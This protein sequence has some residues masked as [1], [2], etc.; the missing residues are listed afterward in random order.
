MKCGGR[1]AR[2]LLAVVVGLGVSARAVPGAAAA[3]TVVWD[4]GGDGVHWSDAANW[5]GDFAPQSGD[6]L[7][8]QAWSCTVASHAPTVNDFP[9]GFVVG[10]VLTPETPFGC[11]VTGNPVELH[12]DIVAASQNGTLTDFHIA[13]VV[14]A[15]DSGQRGFSSFFSDNL[16]LAGHTFTVSGYA[17]L[18]VRDF[19]GG[20]TVHVTGSAAL[21]GSGH[22]RVVMESQP[23]NVLQL[24]G[25]WGVVTI[26]S[27][28]LE[29]YGTADEII[30][31]RTPGNG[32]TTSSTEATTSTSSPPDPDPCACTTLTIL[33]P[34]FPSGPSTT[35]VGAAQA[36][37]PRTGGP[38]LPWIPIAGVGFV[39]LGAFAAR[40]GRRTTR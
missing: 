26:K 8:L 19:V 30:D 6:T 36:E 17:G 35:T 18:T 34:D 24:F 12:G 21:T 40:S 37:L 4:G 27:G 7:D 1:G 28:D 3:T 23:G 25:T 5:V 32:D 9:A 33:V 2:V 20:G 15:G 22:V 39:A 29:N 38:S 11:Y 13:H 31:L 16:D 14:L 10:G